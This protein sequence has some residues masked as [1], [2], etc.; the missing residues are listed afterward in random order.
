[1]E[2]EIKRDEEAAAYKKVSV[3]GLALA[4]PP[5]TGGPSPSTLPSGDLSVISSF[6]EDQ[7]LLDGSIGGN[8]GEYPLSPDRYSLTTDA[9]GPE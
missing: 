6:S 2:Y 9:R 1:M 3:S 5:I 7:M 4:A 8:P